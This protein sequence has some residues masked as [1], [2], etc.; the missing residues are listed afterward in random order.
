MKSK[1]TGKLLK[2]D[3][4][5][6]EDKF[7]WKSTNYTT[8]RT[9]RCTFYLTLFL[10]FVSAFFL[11]ESFI[12]I[13]QG[14]SCL[15]NR[16]V[17][18][19]NLKPDESDI[20]FKDENLSDNEFDQIIKETFFENQPDNQLTKPDFD[21]RLRESFNL[22]YSSKISVGKPNF[23]LSSSPEDPQCSSVKLEERFDCNPDQPINEKVCTSRGCCWKPAEGKNQANII[24]LIIFSIKYISSLL[25]SS[26]WR[27]ILLLS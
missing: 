14:L 16:S 5:I 17:I 2:S 27:A 1:S 10:L 9:F 19:I 15:K 13:L 23:K 4:T 24:R 25:R 20:D 26:C 22:F 3:L 11:L 7:S 18:I 12:G 21:T 8:S 6:I